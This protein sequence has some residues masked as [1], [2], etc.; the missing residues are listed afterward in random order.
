MRLTLVQADVPIELNRR[1]PRDFRRALARCAVRAYGVRRPQPQCSVGTAG[2]DARTVGAERHAVHIG[3]RGVRLR[4]VRGRCRKRHE[5]VPD[6]ELPEGWFTKDA[7][8][9]CLEHWPM[10]RRGATTLKRCAPTARRAGSHP[11]QH[12]LA[13]KSQT[14]ARG[15]AA[16]TRTGTP[17]TPRRGYADRRCPAGSMRARCGDPPRWPG[18]RPGFARKG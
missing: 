18:T 13:E 9:Y 1:S 5:F 15:T 2:G 10:L 11:H 6:L 14:R 4:R 8:S 17:P 3:L 12:R 7:N 16:T